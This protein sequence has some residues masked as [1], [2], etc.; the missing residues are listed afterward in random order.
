[1]SQSTFIISDPAMLIN[2]CVQR[3]I[4]DIS[5]KYVRSV[6]STLRHQSA[7]AGFEAADCSGPSLTL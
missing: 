1:M 2:R 5:M 7:R 4:V 3:F 6:L